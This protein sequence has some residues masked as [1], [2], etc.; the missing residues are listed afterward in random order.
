MKKYNY[1]WAK[2][3]LKITGIILLTQITIESSGVVV[4][5]AGFEYTV[6][7]FAAL[8]LISA[9]YSLVLILLNAK[10]RRKT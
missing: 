3:S 2:A 4:R 7:F 1:F 5:R 6:H 8:F 10:A 9:L